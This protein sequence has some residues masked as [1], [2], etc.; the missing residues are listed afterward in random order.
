MRSTNWNLLG[1]GLALAA[2]SVFGA[3][4]VVAEPA[5]VPAEAFAPT[6]LTAK[7]LPAANDAATP[8]VSLPPKPSAKPVAKSAAKPAAK[9]AAKPAAKAV[10]QP[11]VK[12]AVDA[13]ATSGA[14]PLPRQRPLPPPAASAYAQANV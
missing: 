7:P 5:K 11:A 13:A 1:L 4:F 6:A 9:A 12:P 8:P 2:A 3:A 10:V 14:I